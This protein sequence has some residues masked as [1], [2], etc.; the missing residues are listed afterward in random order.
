MTEIF[1]DEIDLAQQGIVDVEDGKPKKSNMEILADII[2]LDK[3]LAEGKTAKSPAADLLEEELYYEKKAL[4]LIAE[5]ANV[6]LRLK[7][8][9]DPNGIPKLAKY[10]WLRANE[11][12]AREMSSNVV[13]Q[14]RIDKGKAAPKKFGAGTW[15]VP[16]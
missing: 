2:K 10:L 8:M 15:V 9:N 5:P 11:E 16:A 6:K 4:S 13:K 3:L 7:Y 1:K 14:I 12:E